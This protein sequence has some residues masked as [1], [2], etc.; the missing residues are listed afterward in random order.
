MRCQCLNI[1]HI[2]CSRNAS[3]KKGDNNKFCWQHQHCKS[4]LSSS[5]KSSTQIIPHNKKTTKKSPTKKRP[6]KTI[7]PKKKS[8]NKKI[9]TKKIPPKKI[10]VKKIPVK[11]IPVKKIPAK[12]ILVK[13]ITGEK[14]MKKGDEICDLPK[15]I[16]TK[17]I[18]KIYPR[19]V[20][21]LLL[22]SKNCYEKIGL[23]SSFWNSLS[24][25][26]FSNKYIDDNNPKGSIYHYLKQTTDLYV[27]GNNT[28]GRIP[29]KDTVIDTF[30]KVPDIHG[31]I[32]ADSDEFALILL[33]DNGEITISVDHE[34]QFTVNN[35]K[36]ICCTDD[37]TY[38]LDRNNVLYSYGEFIIELLEPEDLNDNRPIK[39]MSNVDKIWKI[40][41]NFGESLVIE[42]NGQLYS[43]LNLAELQ[44]FTENIANIT[45]TL[46]DE[47]GT[48]VDADETGT[49]YIFYRLDFN[50]KTLFDIKGFTTFHFHFTINKGS[51][52]LIDT[53]NNLHTF[54]LLQ[55]GQLGHSI[56]AQ[57][58]KSALMY[59]SSFYWIDMNNNLHR[60]NI[61]DTVLAPN[62]ITISLYQDSLLALDVYGNLFVTGYINPQVHQLISNPNI[63]VDSIHDQL[64]PFQKNVT[65][66]YST[67]SFIV[68]S[69][70]NE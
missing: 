68:L 20:R 41:T 65:M 37:T 11:K 18:G 24:Q 12:K 8:S 26:K 32:K 69:I 23:N 3:S 13:K 58:V 57:N 60:H 64:V 31:I 25:I 51:G 59:S 66:L 39:I 54:M 16:L 46:F 30:K 2:Q 40:T 52:Y 63:L 44:Y 4:P 70:F 62:I 28:D 19:D 22:I 9:L 56:I 55:N 14:N 15:V 7:P 45:P 47:T 27:Y 48:I 1:N 5:K 38:I 21:K 49:I 53:D 17:I 35:I 6:T 67:R 10:P 42:I 50:V 61:I 34:I 33:A 43:E 36:D 29:L